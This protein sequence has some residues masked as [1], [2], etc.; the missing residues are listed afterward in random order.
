MT[1]NA[2]TRQP[3]YILTVASTIAFASFTA[4]FATAHHAIGVTFNMNEIVEIEGEV[5]RIL[6]RNPHVRLNVRMVDENGRAT[7]WWMEGGAVNRLARWG[8]EEGTLATGDSVRLAGYP[9]RRRG[10]EMFGLNLLLPDGREIMMDHRSSPRWRDDAIG[11]ERLS[12]GAASADLGLFRVWT[13]D[14]QNYDIGTNDFPFTDSARAAM[15]AFDPVQDNPLYGCLPKG[16]P[17]IMQQP[18]PI[19]FVESGNEIHLRIEEYDLL[20]VIHMEGAP[21][22]SEPPTI[23]GDSVGRWEEDTLVVGHDQY[24]LALLVRPDRDSAERRNRAG[25]ALHRRRRRCAATLRDHRQRSRDLYRAVD[26]CEVLPVGAG[27]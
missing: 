2:P 19:E 18:F 8:V 4:S 6:W 5:T 26:A 10:N 15:E 3:G 1:R 7:D 24:R 21:E 22:P 23:L 13:S 14:G 27:A 17:T 9:S 12:E 25:R 16:M 20:R 11:G